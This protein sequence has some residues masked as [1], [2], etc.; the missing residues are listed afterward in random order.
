MN[1]ARIAAERHER[2]ELE[3]LRGVLV[4]LAGRPHIGDADR[5]VVLAALRQFEVA[6]RE[7]LAHGPASPEVSARDDLAAEAQL[8]AHPAGLDR[9]R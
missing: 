5:E 3:G 6:V 2:E 7:V 9:R 4:A 8:R 1:E